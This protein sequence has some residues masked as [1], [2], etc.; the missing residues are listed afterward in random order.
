MCV[1]SFGCLKIPFRFIVQSDLPEGCVRFAFSQRPTTTSSSC[2][3]SSLFHTLP[4]L[5]LSRFHPSIRLVREESDPRENWSDSLSPPPV[6][7]LFSVFLLFVFYFSPV[8]PLLLLP[9]SP[10]A[11]ETGRIPL[12]GRKYP[13]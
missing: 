5:L 7:F 2:S 12:Q 6:S 10:R 13:R 8:L 4:R 9:L 3:R 11:G 1:I